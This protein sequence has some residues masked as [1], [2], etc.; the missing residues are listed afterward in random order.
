MINLVAERRE[1]VAEACRRHGVRRLD[2]FGSAAEGGFDPAASDL[3]FLVEFLPLP[4]G[5]RADAYFG[6]LDDLRNLFGRP[7]DLVVDK[8]VRNP[9][10]RAEADRTRTPVYAA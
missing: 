10:F 4:P 5:E 8:A 6:L 3:D 9:Y 7:V 2:L 1:Q